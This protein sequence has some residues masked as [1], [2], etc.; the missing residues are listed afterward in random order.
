[1]K[2]LLGFVVLL[3]CLMGSLNAG[4]ASFR[5]VQLQNQRVK[6]AFLE[7][8]FDF[9]S[10]LRNLG[11]DPTSFEIYIRVFK[12]E[13]E[14]ELWA[15]S[16][17]KREYKLVETYKFCENVGF[18]GPKRRQGDGQIPEGLYEINSFNPQSN[19]YL[20]LQVNYP[21]RADQLREGPAD[22]GG[23]I[24]IHGG[25]QTIG[26]VPITDDK[27]KELYVAAVLAKSL[28]QGVIQVHFF[29]NRLS[30]EHYKQLATETTD[31]ELV[32]FWGNLR[33]C[34]VYFN[35]YKFPPLIQVDNDG[36]YIYKHPYGT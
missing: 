29:P 17:N 25:C 27:I 10:R 31:T 26:C 24:F 1:M 16:K 5:D 19:Y 28:G 6:Q 15:R 21:N 3:L 8:E 23:L 9:K 13:E 2:R 34:I 30:P 35:K 7:K 32:R 36:S 20:S 33:T 11:V 12:V 4:K 18:P 22:L 14:L